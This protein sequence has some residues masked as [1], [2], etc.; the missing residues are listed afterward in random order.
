MK[1]KKNIKSLISVI[2]ASLFILCCF[3]ACNGDKEDETTTPDTTVETVV[4]D[5]N[6]ET[7]EDATEEVTSETEMN[8]TPEENNLQEKTTND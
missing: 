6:K 8:E 2:L 5:E 4:T 1:M 7:T 3:A